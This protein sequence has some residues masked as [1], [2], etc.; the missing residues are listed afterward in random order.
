MVL[1][2]IRNKYI[3]GLDARFII[4]HDLVGY[5]RA[6]EAFRNAG[7]STYPEDHD[8]GYI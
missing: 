6:L 8:W 4:E 5:R 7:L 2:E 1:K 3:S